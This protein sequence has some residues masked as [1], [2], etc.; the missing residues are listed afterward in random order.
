MSIPIS[1]A[2]NWKEFSERVEE[3]EL[4]HDVKLINPGLGEVVTL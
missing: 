1:I 2:G 3:S 4:I